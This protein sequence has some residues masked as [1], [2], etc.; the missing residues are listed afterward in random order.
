MREGYRR[1]AVNNIIVNNSLH[2]H[3][4]YP[5]SQDEIEHNVLMGGCRTIAMDPNWDG[6][7]VDYNLYTTSNADRVKYSRNG[8]GVHS[9]VGDPQ[10][11][12]PSKGDFTVRNKALA[13]RVGFKNFPMDQFGVKKPSLRRMAKTPAMPEVDIHPDLSPVKAKP[14]SHVTVWQRAYLSEPKGEAL[15]AYGAD[16]D[17]GG[18]AID[19][20][21]RRSP[22]AGANGLKPG[23]LIQGLNGKKIESIADL[24]R[25]AHQAK[26]GRLEFRVLRSQSE[27]TVRIVLKN[28]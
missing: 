9:V 3:V 26:D 24:Q 20:L 4:W 10:F 13:S 27:T 19:Q 1:V 16:L 22:L 8:C 2:L 7:R 15:S 14:K 17:G 28:R 6:D 11:A 5:G 18:V 25:I 21:H 23:D 12:D